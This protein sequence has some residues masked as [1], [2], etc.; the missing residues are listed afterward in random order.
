VHKLMGV[1]LGG[2]V[3]VVRDECLNFLYVLLVYPY[4]HSIKTKIMSHIYQTID[5]PSVIIF[6]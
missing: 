4:S 3:L 6:R 1:F 5:L 2:G